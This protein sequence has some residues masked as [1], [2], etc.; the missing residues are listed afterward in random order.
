[1]LED[2]IHINNLCFEIQQ[3]SGSEKKLVKPLQNFFFDLI[4]IEKGS[5]WTTPKMEKKIFGRNNNRSSVFRKFLFY[6]NIICFDWV[7]NLFLSSVMFLSKK[8]HFQLKQLWYTLKWKK[9][10]ATWFQR[11][12]EFWAYMSMFYGVYKVTGKNE[13]Q[14]P[15][16]ALTWRTDRWIYRKKTTPHA[17]FNLGDGDHYVSSPDYPPLLL[18]PLLPREYFL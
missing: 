18:S 10:E 7:M 8:C 13:G 11:S 12:L 1:M 16:P 5:L 17:F 15:S 4:C 3:F 9:R 2:T 14:F 6:Q